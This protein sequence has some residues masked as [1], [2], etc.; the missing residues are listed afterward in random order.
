MPKAEPL[1]IAGRLIR[2]LGY[3]RACRLERLAGGRNNRVYRIEIAGQRDPLV[4]KSYFY[5]PED[6][7]DR[8]GAEWA[9]STFAWARGVRSMPE[10]LVCDGEARAALFRF[11]PGERPL[12]GT[13]AAGD[14]GQALALLREV[15]RCRNAA[16]LLPTA[17]EACF[18]LAEHVATIERRLA[19]LLALDDEAPL[20]AAVRAFAADEVAPLF[21]ALVARLRRSV[22]AHGIAADHVLAPSERCLSPSDFGFHNALR[23][24]LGTVR[25]L[26]FEY[27]G[28]DDPAK[29]VGDFFNQVAV[30]VPEEHY[31]P[32]TEGLIE[33]LELGPA[34]RLRFDL[35]RRLYAVKWAVILLNEFCRSDRARRA[36]AAAA[37]EEP[38]LAGQLALARRKLRSLD[39]W[40]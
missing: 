19:R 22:E 33:A 6:R 27:A 37:V 13:I 32:F 2:R 11:V 40:L 1:E 18:S 9:F 36:Y 34:E 10:P 35:F 21:R 17:S 24:D 20:A 38:G 39:D 23:D 15:N 14:V 12:P 5:S 26:D 7:R 16:A 8:L 29:L 3:D 31:A 30:P 4:L 25:F 28:W